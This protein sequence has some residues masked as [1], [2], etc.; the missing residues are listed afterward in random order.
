MWGGYLGQ[1]DGRV[2]ADERQRRRSRPLEAPP[3]LA[4]AFA[5]ACGKH[6]FLIVSGLRLG[7]FYIV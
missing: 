3:L 7:F 2:L 5:L 1:V 6:V 4:R